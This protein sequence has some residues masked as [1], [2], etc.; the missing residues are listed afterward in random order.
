MIYQLRNRLPVLIVIVF[1]LCM[2]IVEVSTAA[3]ESQ[4]IDEAV[5]IAS[6]ASY[7]LTGDYRMNPEHPPLIKL[8]AT[9]PLAIARVSTFTDNVAWIHWNEWEYGDYFL[10]HNIFSVQTLLMLCRIP[11]MLL[12]IALGWLIFKASSELFGQWGGVVS[13][14]FYSFD[15]NIIAHSRYVTTDLGFTVFAFLSIYCLAKVLQHPSVRNGVWFIVSFFAMSMAKFSS[16][17]F[18]LIIIL[19]IVLIKIVHRDHAALQ[20]RTIRRWLAI[21]VPL[22]L[23]STWMLYGF[24]IRAPSND[25]RIRQLYSQREE[26]LSAHDPQTLPPLERFVMTTMGDRG[27]DLGQWLERSSSIRIP[28]YAFFR[29]FFT[30]IGHNIGGQESYLLGHVSE[31][32]WWY[33]FPVAFITKTPFPTLIAILGMFLVC[34]AGSI[35]AIRKRTWLRTVRALPFSVVLYVLTPVL[36][37]GISMGSHLNLGWRHIMPI[38]PFMFVLIGSLVKLPGIEHFKFGTIIPVVLACNLAAIQFVTYPNEIGYF[39]NLIGRSTN[40]P[41]YLLDS[42]L[43]WGQDLPKLVEY[44]RANNINR[45]PFAYYGRATVSYYLPQAVALPTTADVQNNPASFPHGTVAISIGE[46]LRKDKAYSWLWQ[47]TP[48]TVV[49]SSIYIYSIN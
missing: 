44:V 49:G 2:F 23:L 42:N 43:D 41:H 10:Y 46:L 27:Q 11:I 9:L 45:L 15:P 29:G 4:I 32:G 18:T 16:L 31:R 48:H 24:D 38:Y 1:L 14:A 12:S 30:V 3:R 39:N 21:S 37:F 5:H 8:I 19:L 35:T 36:F 20:W 33:Y 6:G 28:G 7:W 34:C 26:Y 22:L 25:P 40:G 47:F 17:P 13:V